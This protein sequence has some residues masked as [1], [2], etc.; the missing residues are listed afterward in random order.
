M[1]LWRISSARTSAPAH[2]VHSLT[3]GCRNTAPI[4]EKGKLRSWVG[5]NGQYYRELPC[6]S[7]RGRG[8]T[9]CKQCGVDRSSLD[10]PMCNG[11]GIKVCL[12][13]GGECVI[14]Q[15]SIDEQP[16]EKV[17]SSSPLKV[18]EDDEVDKLEINIDT[19]KR[20]KRTYPS[21]SPEVAMK[22]SR[23][24]RSLNAQ[25]GLFTKHMKII[26]QDP[27]LHAQR[28]A[29]IKRTKGTAAARKHASE[30][31][32]AFFS[33][34]EN[35]LKRSIAMKGVKFHCSRC[36]QEG[37]RSFYCPTVRKGSA[38]VQFKCRLCGMEGHNSRTCGKPKSEKEQ[39]RQ[40]RHCGRCGEKGHNR[41]NCPRSTNVDI[42]AS[43]YTTNKVTGPNSGIYS[44][45]FCLEK[46]HNRQTCPKRKASLGK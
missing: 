5:P 4:A 19:P 8:Y 20:S 6:P 11:K 40:P 44:C 21:P 31:Q 34:P 28:V 29:A 1:T 16:W 18:K 41:R 38:R 36:G 37:H 30:T 26:H 32:K 24:L 35:R 25:T 3:F 45:S 27:E 13:C 22:I 2:H 23:S 14:W 39:Q 42:G 15:E 10:C 9:P 46:G 33:N 12:Q 7:C 43:G 17:R